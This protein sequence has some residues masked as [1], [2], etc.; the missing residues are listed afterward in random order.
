M[1]LRLGQE[2][3]EAEA[4]NWQLL[5]AACDTKPPGRNWPAGKQ[6]SGYMRKPR[7]G[8]AGK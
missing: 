5:S 1:N 8:Q 7:T 4:H 6:D 2:D 3:W